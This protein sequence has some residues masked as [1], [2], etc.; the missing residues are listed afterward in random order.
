[1]PLYRAAD[2]FTVSLHESAAVSQ[3]LDELT[4]GG[5]SR[6]P[7]KVDRWLTDDELTVSIGGVA[8]GIEAALDGLTG[9]DWVAPSFI[10]GQSGQRQW[11]TDEIVVALEPA[12]DPAAFFGTDTFSGYSR[13]LGTT[14]QFVGKVTAGG[15]GAL[16]VANALYFDPRVV[17]SRPIFTATS[18]PPPRP[19]TVCSTHSGTCTIRDRVGHERRGCPI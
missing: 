9:V 15:L 14:D 10:N 19:T 2:E 11:L 7:I 1:M 12:V 13:L 17:W 4:S 18:G 8:D 3:L 16:D 6:P 5:K